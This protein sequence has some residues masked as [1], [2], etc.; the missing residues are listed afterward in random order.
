MLDE[1]EAA[2]NRVAQAVEMKKV[3]LDD[4]MSTEER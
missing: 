1:A 4:L 3:K 2:F